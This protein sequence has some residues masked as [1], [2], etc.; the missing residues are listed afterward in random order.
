M[1]KKTR[2]SMLFCP[3]DNPK[4]FFTGMVYTPDCIVF[5]LEDAVKISNKEA[6]R[7]LLVEALKTIDYKNIEIF[8]RINPLSTP[9]GE[10]D[11]R[12]L[13][14]AGLRKIRLPMCEV[15]EHILE[16]DKLLSEIEKDN[17]IE[18]G[19]V[20]IQSGIE[21]PKGVHNAYS[22]VTASSRVIALS[23]GAEDYTKS[24]G[25]ERTKKGDEVFTARSYLAM[26]ASMVGID[27]I[28]TVWSDIKDEEGF[29]AETKK[30]KS[31]GFSGK[32]CIHPNQI[33]YVHNVY[34]PSK[35]EME[36]SLEILKIS[37]NMKIEEGGVISLHGKMIDIPVIEKAKK[38]IRQAQAAGILKD[39]EDFKYE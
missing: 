29:I 34:L 10:K 14:K 2:R 11:V 9:F 33:K 17:G 13:V 39:M 32:S 12:E 18:V 19:A 4:M 5:D 3:A 31:L 28:D 25:V 38:I 7:D 35:E 1:N 36:K 22:I 16:L 30:I 26:I 27:A 24:L 6:A 21:T 8:A 23:F 20:K 15:K 37:K